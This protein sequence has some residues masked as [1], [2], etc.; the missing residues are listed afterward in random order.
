MRAG[1]GR[2]YIA[3]I[4]VGDGPFFDA[5]DADIGEGH[6]LALFVPDGAFDNALL[7]LYGKGKCGQNGDRDNVPHLIFLNKSR[8]KGTPAGDAYIYAKRKIYD[9]IG[10][11]C[12]RSGTGNVTTCQ[13]FNSALTKYNVNVMV[14]P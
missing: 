10:K 2:E 14:L 7:G 8:R 1:G 12:G 6:G 3:A 13:H 9:R 11:N 4:S 5:R